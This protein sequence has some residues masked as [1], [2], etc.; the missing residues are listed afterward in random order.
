MIAFLSLFA[1]LII[2]TGLFVLLGIRPV[3]ISCGNDTSR[4]DPIPKW[5][6]KE[7]EEEE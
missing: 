5:A 6:K 7:D 4:I 1:L 2:M 3:I